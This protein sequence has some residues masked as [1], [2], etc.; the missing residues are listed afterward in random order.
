M[1]LTGKSGSVTDHSGIATY[2]SSDNKIKDLLVRGQLLVTESRNVPLVVVGIPFEQVLNFFVESL[3]R[4][5]PE[6][7][8]CSHVVIPVPSHGQVRASD[9]VRPAIPL[10]SEMV[11]PELETVV[12]RP[13]PAHVIASQTPDIRNSDIIH[14]S[15]SESFVTF[16]RADVQRAGRRRNM[17]GKVHQEQEVGRGHREREP[18]GTERTEITRSGNKCQSI[19]K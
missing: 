15:W 14:K 12:V 19:K 18:V 1:T 7:E 11:Q 8:C 10:A 5:N 9:T 17:I 13:P 3:T 2:Q 4:L 6:L 16:T